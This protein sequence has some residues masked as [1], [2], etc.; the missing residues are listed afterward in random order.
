MVP[1]EPHPP[2]RPPRF[3]RPLAGFLCGVAITAGVWSLTQ[4]TEE[5]RM[6]DLQAAQ[7][8]DMTGQLQSRMKSLEEVLLG[9]SGFLGRGPLPTR[10]EFRDYVEGL[11]LPVLYPGVQ[12]LGFVAWNPEPGPE[13]RSAILYLEPADDRNL[14]ALGR[15]MLTDPVRR[16]AMVK[17]RD[18][19][20]LALSAPVVLYQETGTDVQTGT[21]LYAPVYDRRLPRE[22]LAQRRAAF[23]G[24]TSI[25]F[26]M[27]DL[28][29]AALAR[30][31]ALGD[32]SLTDAGAG[33]PGQLLYESRPGAGGMGLG[34]RV[35]VGDREWTL[36]VRSGPAFFA[37][38]GHRNH[39]EILA[40][41][42][43][44]S[45]GLGAVLALYQGAEDRARRRAEA[46]ARELRDT[47]ARFQT[48]FRK[49]PVGMAIVDTATGRFLTVNPRLEQILGYSSA[50][51]KERTFLAM[52]HPDHVASDL[53][54]MAELISGA[55][56]EYAKEKRYLHR[57]GHVVWGRVRV[58][59]LPR[60][61]GADPR[62]LA[63]VED[64]TDRIQVMESL[65]R[66][67]ARFRNLVENAVDPIVLFDAEG[68]ILLANGEASRLT[69][70]SREEFAEMRV[71]DLSPEMP[72]EEYARI[73]NGL[74]FGESRRFEG[75][76]RRKDGTTFPVEVRIGLLE[77]GEPRQILSMVRDLSAVDLAAQ[78]EA[79]A[80]KAESLVL[81]AGGIAHDF[82]NVFQA[83]Q[84]NLE[85]AGFLTRGKDDLTQVLDQARLALGRAVVLARKMLDFS[86]RGIVRPVPLDLAAL[87]ERIPAVPG[88]EVQRD[89]L[90]VPQVLGDAG[91]LEQVVTAL[92]E[93]AR[94]AGASRVQLQLRTHTG[95][96]SAA[97]QGFWALSRFHGAGAVCLRVRDDGPGVPP[98]RLSL[99]CDPFYT[100]RE[101]GRGLGLAAA[102]GILKAH[103][104][105][106]HLR[107]GEDGGL[108]A[109]LFFRQA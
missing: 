99:V 24:W 91:K 46:M 13:G 82:N 38:T 63:L 35:R 56:E 60:E 1:A 103:R 31:L 52:T 32:F 62:H 11:R 5:R 58:A 69:G 12:G 89:F 97:D 71:Q 53:V 73:W 79:R 45:L 41:G 21:V 90:P 3:F 48:V 96:E 92:L 107:N 20:I 6:A 83:V 106:F 81:M 34:G 10:E 76:T 25:P 19:G 28:A 93:N 101:P 64:I 29:R 94:E 98:E 68:R 16:Q 44:L 74:D 42:L 30:D 17:A 23:R 78:S 49:A 84:S 75:L 108:V 102:V 15:E 77:P 50:E 67:E 4:R 7:A 86:G 70:Y 18:Q 26:R 14:R 40:A 43:V 51:L 55:V 88:L 22:T 33:G 2:A 37:A 105:G 47:E 9:T 36:R 27:G 61:E 39:W 57:D 72:M 59:R 100:T 80:R 65:R 95:A 54:S 85:I 104:A 87:L 109:R 8:R 66:D